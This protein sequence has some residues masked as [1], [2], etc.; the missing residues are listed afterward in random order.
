MG[1]GP[2]L[3]QRT[4]HGSGNLCAV[5]VS[6]Q[7]LAADGTEI[8]FDQEGAGPDIAWV[9]GICEDRASWTPITSQFIREFR[10]TR[11]DLRGH[12]E[13]ARL[14]QYDPG[15]FIAD[16]SAVIT[17]TC[18]T[19]PVVVGHSL[20]G[21]IA[22]VASALGMTGP[23]ICIDQPLKAGSLARLVHQLAP[24]LRDPT[25]FPDALIEEKIALG[26]DLVPGPMFTRLEELTRMCDQTMVLDTWQPMLDADTDTLEANDAALEAILPS[27]DEP[28]LALHGSAVSEE[29]ANWFGRT[30]SSGT[31]E[32]WDGCGHWPHLVDPKRFVDRI[33]SFLA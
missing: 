10:C 17:T 26:M 6:G 15:M 13:S 5:R 29:Y 32:V 2:I 20:G 19:K 12:G 22:T 24:R 18:T 4:E 25:R 28:Y 14:A 33:R 30:I 3:G 27:I 9:H 1:P 23:V 21:L 16:V 31:L 7:V 11:L 8:A